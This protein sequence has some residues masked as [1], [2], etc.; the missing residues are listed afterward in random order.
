[1]RILMAARLVRTIFPLLA[2]FLWSLVSPLFALSGSGERAEMD[3]NTLTIAFYNVENLYDTEDDPRTD[4]REFLPGGSKQWNFKR[5]SKKISDLARVISELGGKELPEIV[6]LCEVENDKVLLDLVNHPDLSP[7][8]YRFVRFN[9]RDSRGIDL[10]FL[11]RPDEFRL[12]SSQLVPVRSSRGGRFARGILYITGQAKNGEIF[13]IFV[14]H[15]PSRENNTDQREGGREEMAAALRHLTDEL[16]L[17]DMNAGIVIMGDM[18]DEPD[19][20]SLSRILAAVPPGRHSASGLVNLMYPARLK[21]SGTVKFRKEWKMLDNL[22][23]SESLLDNRGYRVNDGK[24]FVFSAGWMEF[25]TRQGEV[26]PNRTYVG[27]RYAGG[28]SDHF[29]VYFRMITSPL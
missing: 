11:Y 13:H 26:S 25:R 14:N 8:H 7:G 3:D 19:N 16:R 20:I 5:Y 1:M 9:D 17:K 10:A 21:G 23:V 22:I 24:G 27:N 28:V 15:W 4:D 29:P 2:I 6:G 18:N 12:L